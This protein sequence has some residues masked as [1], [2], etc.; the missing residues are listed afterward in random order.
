MPRFPEY[1]LGKVEE[2][3]NYSHKI[4]CLALGI[5][6]SYLRGDLHPSQFMIE[7]YL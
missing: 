7:F 4:F 6:L 1:L 3:G 5:L 2:K